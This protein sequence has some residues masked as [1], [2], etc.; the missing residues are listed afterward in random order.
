[1]TPIETI[2]LVCGV[3]AILFP[4]CVVVVVMI[5]DAIYD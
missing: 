1:M 2:F 5:L 3:S 4:F